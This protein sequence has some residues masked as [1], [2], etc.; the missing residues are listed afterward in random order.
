[1]RAA[2]R[3]LVVAGIVV[4]PLAAQQPASVYEVASVKPNRTP[5]PVT[6]MQAAPGRYG[7]TA[8]TLKTLVA[9][10]HQRSAFDQ[11]EVVGGPEWV[12]ADRFDVVVQAPAGAT[13]TDPDGFPGPVF[14]MIRAVLV[15]R[16]GL[17]VHN[18][19]RERPVYALTIARADRRLGDGLKRVDAGCAD[20]MRRLAAPTPGAPTAGPPPCSFGGGPGQLIGTSV[21]LA[22]VASVLSRQVGRPIVDRTGIADSFNVVL[23]FAPE[24]D[25]RT[26]NGP[27]STPPAAVGDAPSIFT[28]LQEQLG[29]KLE[30]TRA[31]VDVLVIDKAS[32]PTEN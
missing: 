16:F 26:S 19:V 20:A 10:S 15:D 31:P 18:E 7:W 8:A 4:A 3:A 2:V 9:V 1:V 6:R 21:S 25:A 17:A 24:S 28:A 14:A 22:M 23:T 32:Q 12:D 5:A 13:L 11:R 30:S 29:L 27:P